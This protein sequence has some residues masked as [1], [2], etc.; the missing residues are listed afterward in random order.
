MIIVDWSATATP[1]PAAPSADRCWIA[2]STENTSPEAEYF[3]TRRDCIARIFNLLDGRTGPAFVGFDFPFGYPVG[4]GLGGGRH[5]ADR[6][7]SKLVSESNDR[8]NRFDVAVTLNI[9]ISAHPGPFWGCPPRFDSPDLTLK[10]PPF[11]HENF[12]E[13][14]TVERYLRSQKYQ[15]MN[16]WQLMGAGCVGSQTLTGLKAL[17]D[18]ARHPAFIDA[19]KFWPFETDWDLHLEGIILTEIWPSLHDLSSY[20]HPIKDARQVL[21]CRDWIIDHNRNGTLRQL[22]AAPNWLTPAENKICREEEGWILGVGR[23]G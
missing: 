3:R 20:D 21:A 4:S 1:G 19:V 11:R 8:N 13:W 22:F 15:I 7:A 14:R 23:P 18:I 2:W 17:D 12:N 16:V 6:I 5:A 10:K 9:G